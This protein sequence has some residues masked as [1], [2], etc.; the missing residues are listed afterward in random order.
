[1]AIFILDNID[2]CFNNK[3]ESVVYRNYNPKKPNFEKKVLVLGPNFMELV[4]VMTLD[5]TQHAASLRL[6][7]RTLTRGQFDSVYFPHVPLHQQPL[8]K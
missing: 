4:V 3:T 2:I 7:C 5:C 8:C 1:M 6:L